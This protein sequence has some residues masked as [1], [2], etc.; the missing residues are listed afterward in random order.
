MFKIIIKFLLLSVLIS[1]INCS[2]THN[3]KAPFTKISIKGDSA[4]TI[5]RPTEIGFEVKDQVI[6]GTALSKT[7]MG[8][9]TLDQYDESLFAIFRGVEKGKLT[10]IARIAALKAIDSVKADGILITRIK[11]TGKHYFFASNTKV[12]VVGK[13]LFFKSYGVVS[14]KRADQTLQDLKEKYEFQLNKDL[15]KKWKNIV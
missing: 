9:N 2:T 6:M 4:Y 12:T 8:F 10:G 14:E 3:I 5:G 11:E 7:V 15:G 1:S 13:P